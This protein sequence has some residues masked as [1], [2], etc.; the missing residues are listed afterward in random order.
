[1]VG[2]S[3]DDEVETVKSKQ[4]KNFINGEMLCEKILWQR[5]FAT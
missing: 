4:G 3:K 2:G 5:G 1:M